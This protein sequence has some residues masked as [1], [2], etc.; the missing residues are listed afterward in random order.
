MVPWTN[1]G[2]K[3]A[4]KDKSSI[5]HT[6]F[7]RQKLGDLNAKDGNKWNGGVSCEWDGG[8]TEVIKS[9]NNARNHAETKVVMK[10]VHLATIEAEIDEEGSGWER[11]RK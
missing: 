3:A 7:V 10:G 4:W 5:L 11:V 8:L 1:T 9:A 6:P 2:K